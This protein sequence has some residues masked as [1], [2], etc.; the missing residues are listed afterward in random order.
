MLNL[1]VLG[2][3]TVAFAICFRVASAQESEPVEAIEQVPEHVERIIRLEHGMT[4]D[5]HELVGIF[6]DRNMRPV[7]R[8]G[9]GDQLIAHVPELIIRESGELGWLRVTG[10]EERVRAFEEAVREIDVAPEPPANLEIVF[11]LLS[12]TE[13]EGR[14][15]YPDALEPVIAQLEKTFQYGTYA[16]IDTALVRTRVG[17]ELS[18]EATIPVNRLPVKYDEFVPANYSVNLETDRPMTTGQFPV[19]VFVGISLEVPYETIVRNEKHT[20]YRNIGAQMKSAMD[21]REG[22]S[23]VLGK[24]NFDQS[25]DALFVVMQ[26]IKVD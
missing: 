15:E 26:L 17:E 11:Y 7:P 12:A 23:I 2:I 1:R 9:S 19:E 6:N 21:I 3:A 5:I 13:K 16:V 14:H 18:H 4:R 22:Q 8:S 24:S 25:N 20:Q 10:T